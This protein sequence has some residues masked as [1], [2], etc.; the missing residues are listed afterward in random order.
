MRPTIHVSE[1]LLESADLDRLPRQRYETNWAGARVDFQAEFTLA[2]DSEF[3]HQKAWCGLEP[4]CD[5]SL[6]AGQFQAELWKRDVAELFVLDPATGL[7]REWNLSPIGAWWTDR[8]IAERQRDLSYEAELNGVRTSGEATEGK[9]GWIA[10]IS[11]PRSEFGELSSCRVNVP[12][13][14]RGNFMSCC[15]ESK[16]EPDFHNIQAFP[17]PVLCSIEGKF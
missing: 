17:A 13:I 5:F 4:D 1:Q 3:L 6:A 7:Y 11:I 9:S 2:L 8:Y 16:H 10:Q 12:M 14:A 15:Q